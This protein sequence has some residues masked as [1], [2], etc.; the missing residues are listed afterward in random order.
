[1]G[2]V[3]I[4]GGA[5]LPLEQ[6][7]LV[8]HLPGD[9][10]KTASKYVNE[11][12]RRG[13][14]TVYVPVGTDNNDNNSQSSRI[15]SEIIN[16]EES[17]NRGN[18]LTLDIRSFYSSALAGDLQPFE[19][20]KILLEEAIKERIASAKNGEVTFVSGIGGTLAANQ[21]FEE[22]INAEEWWHKT[23]SEWLQ[24]GLRVTIICSHPYA[25]IEKKSH[26][27][28]LAHYKQAMSSLHHIVVD[29]SST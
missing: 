18:L 23:H 22:S 11:A 17:V 15:E 25:I 16:Y 19:E 9:N 20:L 3:G 5:K 8:L 21:K 4:Y 29:P 13:Q 12:L 14:M 26:E 28:Q 2:S 27:Q 6:H 10:G 7:S 24:K 1:L